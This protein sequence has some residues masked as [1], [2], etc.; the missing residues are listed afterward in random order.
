VN[1]HLAGKIL[2]EVRNAQTSTMHL[3]HPRPV[4]WDD[5]AKV[6]SREL[7][8][9]VVPYAEWVRRLEEAGNKSSQ[10]PK[11]SIEALPA[12]L[13]LDFFKGAVTSATSDASHTK[14]FM[15]TPNLSIDEALKASMTLSDAEVMGQLGEDDVCRWL[16]FWKSANH[17]TQ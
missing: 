17:I 16:E 8:L 15:G 13:L 11:P 6:F 10:S 9:P 7:K 3:V 5:L 12:I 4:Q 2:A 1:L 14:G